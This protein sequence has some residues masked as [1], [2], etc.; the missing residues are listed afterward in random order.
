MEKNVYTAPE[1]LV[2]EM[3]LVSMIAGS[4]IEVKPGEGDDFELESNR[5]RGEWGNLW[6]DINK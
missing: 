2:I 3:E 1:C 4:V 5:H 6:S